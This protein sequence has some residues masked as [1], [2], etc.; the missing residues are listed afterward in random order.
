MRRTIIMTADD[1]GMCLEV[2]EAI[3]EYFESGALRAT[4]VMPNLPLY[5]K[6]GFLRTR[7]S[8]CSIGINFFRS[9]T[10]VCLSATILSKIFMLICLIPLRF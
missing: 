6:A 4:C 8:N 3:E 1:Y 2:N 9:S 5:E 10:S 7:F